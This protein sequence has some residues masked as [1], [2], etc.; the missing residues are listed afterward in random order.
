MASANS[1]TRSRS[2]LLVASSRRSGTSRMAGTRQRLGFHVRRPE[3]PADETNPRGFAESQWVVDFH[4]KLLDRAGVQTS[5]ARPAAWALTAQVGL[6]QDIIAELQSWL[7]RQFATAPDIVIKDPRLS[8]FLPLW[9]R[10]AAALG[11]E[12]KVVTMLRH[13]AAVVDSKTR[14]Y[15]EWQGRVARTAGWVQQ[16]LY[17]E[18]ATRDSPRVLVHYEDLLEDWTRVVGRVGDV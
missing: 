6:N 8:W 3:V 5:D 1:H 17:L 18:R 7:P 15:G 9:R 2:L 14:W 10:R 13:P 16:A 4:T 11:V 12:A